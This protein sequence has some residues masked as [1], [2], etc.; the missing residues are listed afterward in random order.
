MTQEDEDGGALWEARWFAVSQMRPKLCIILSLAKGLVPIDSISEGNLKLFH[1][2]APK[3]LPISCVLSTGEAQLTVIP[4]AFFLVLASYFV[5]SPP[6][7][8][9]ILSESNQ[10]VI[11]VWIALHGLDTACCSHN[12]T[13]LHLLSAHYKL[14]IDVCANW[15]WIVWFWKQTLVVLILFSRW[16]NWG[17]T[18]NPL[19]GVIGVLSGRNGMLTKVIQWG[20]LS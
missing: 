17:L 4:L 2:K 1:I 3:F 20:L 10:T 13:N 12:N 9:A 7:I 15:N 18:L 6:P 11:K 19:F 5:F 8:F 16:G 14:G